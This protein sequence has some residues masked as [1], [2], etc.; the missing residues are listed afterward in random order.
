MKVGITPKIEESALELF[1][2]IFRKKNGAPN[3]QGGATYI[4]EAFRAIYRQNLLDLKGKFS[5][6]EIKLML[7]AV[8]DSELSSEF[9]GRRLMEHTMDSISLDG[10]L[11]EFGVDLVE[12]TE[13]LGKLSVPQLAYLE[14]W[15]QAYWNQV[16]DA[17]ALEIDEYIKP[18][19]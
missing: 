19:L 5:P 17:A 3:P 12:F 10:A 8:K 1:G 15:M 2:Q 6:Q 16:N 18:I 11:A 7:H 13:E 9:A 4:V 14:L